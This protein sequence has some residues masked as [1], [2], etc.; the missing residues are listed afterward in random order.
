MPFFI[1]DGFVLECFA[2]LWA[3]FRYLSNI[4]LTA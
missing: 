2:A 3:L 1:V 4:I